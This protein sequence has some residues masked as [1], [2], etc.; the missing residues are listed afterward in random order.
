MGFFGFDLGP[1]YQAAL[2]VPWSLLIGSVGVDE[3]QGE[4]VCL[5]R[6]RERLTS[7]QNL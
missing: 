1:L 3:V 2:G 7:V 6:S 5:L 4:G